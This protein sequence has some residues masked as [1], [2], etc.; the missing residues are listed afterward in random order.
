M[1]ALRRGGGSARK[2][3]PATSAGTASRGLAVG[4]R[5]WWPAQGLGCPCC[6]PLR[7]VQRAL[8]ACGRGRSAGTLG[9][10]CLASL[11]PVLSWG[12]SA[13]W[14]ASVPLEGFGEISVT[15][16]GCWPWGRTLEAWGPVPPLPRRRSTLLGGQG[17]R[18]APGELI[19]HGLCL[20]VLASQGTGCLPG[21]PGSWAAR[22]V[23]VGRCLKWPKRQ[24]PKASESPP[25][26]PPGGLGAGGLAAMAIQAPAAA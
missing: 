14:A 18:A 21:P 9:G 24:D 1:I 11:G 17:L 20:C 8:L 6:F 15:C 3:G 16:L 2:H 4:P 19:G 10:T 13:S 7:W 5:G 23:G 22:G 26:E 12:P 25:Q